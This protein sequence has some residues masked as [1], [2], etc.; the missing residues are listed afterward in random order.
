MALCMS[1]C[2]RNWYE[3]HHMKMAIVR[4]AEAHFLVEEE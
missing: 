3:N 1:Y 4:A 2:I